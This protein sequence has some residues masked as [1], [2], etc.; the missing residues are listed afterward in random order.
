MILDMKSNEGICFLGENPCLLKEAW[1]SIY[2][3]T[4]ASTQGLGFCGIIRKIAPF[5]GQ[6]TQ[7][8]GI[9]CP[10]NVSRTL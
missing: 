4:S 3:S 6:F 10:L 9:Y 1:R 5:G 7:D 2:H 8:M